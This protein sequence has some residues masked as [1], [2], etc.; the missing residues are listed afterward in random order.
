M[1][2]IC[3]LCFGSRLVENKKEKIDPLKFMLINNVAMVTYVFNKLLHLL[4]NM[5][6]SVL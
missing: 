3:V 2:T 5:I 4:F 6:I 1:Y